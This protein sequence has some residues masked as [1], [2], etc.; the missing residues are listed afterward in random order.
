MDA[1]YLLLLSAAVSVVTAAIKAA[2][3][4]RLHHLLPLTPLLLGAIGGVLTGLTPAESGGAAA[5]WGVL[6]GAFS[7]QAYEALKTYLRLGKTG[8]TIQP[9][10]LTDTK[11]EETKT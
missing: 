10:E 1:F 4:A 8:Y 5:V 6:A 11:K 2:L 7:G 3:P 9:G